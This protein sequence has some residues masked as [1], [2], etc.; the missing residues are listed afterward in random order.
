VSSVV[1]SA[2]GYD[3][4]LAHNAAS[5]ASCQASPGLAAHM[6]LRDQLRDLD[7]LRSALGQPR[8][9]WLGQADGS[10]LADAYAATYP[11]RIGQMVLDASVDPNRSAAGRAFDAAVAEEAAFDHFAAW[12]SNEPACALHGKDV[13]RIFDQVVAKADAGEVSTEGT[14][15]RSLT[16][17]EIRITAGQYLVGYPFAWPGLATGIAEA[18]TGNGQVFATYAAMTYTDPDYTASRLQTCGDTPAPSRLPQL[19]A[20]ATTVRRIAP[21]T[22]GV[23][24][25]WEAMAGCVGRQANQPFT[26]PARVRPGATI[27]VTGTTGDPVSPYAWTRSVATELDGSRLLTATVDG[28]GAFDNSGCADSIIDGY[29]AGG[30]PPATNVVCPD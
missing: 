21:H 26:L 6:G 2:D 5:Y 16:G 8:L 27:L 15:P 20:L 19:A 9:N 12:C 23:S 3:L 28:H 24:I 4:L 30:A 17:A 1:T 25:A 13:G 22:G 29:L 18:A 14:T 7:A 11:G 10:E